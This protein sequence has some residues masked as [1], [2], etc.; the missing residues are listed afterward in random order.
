MKPEKLRSVRCL[1]LLLGL[2]VACDDDVP[3]EGDTAG[4][5]DDGVD[6]DLDG[7]IDCADDG[8]AAA[9]A[10]VA[11]DDDDSGSDDDDS[12]SDDDD[13]TPGSDPC[14]DILTFETDLS[15]TRELWVDVAAP[16]GGD[17]STTAPFSTI[18]SAVDVAGPGDAVRIRPGTYPGSNYFSDVQGTETEPIWIGGVPGE[19]RPV[20]DADGSNEGLHFTRPRYLVV[21]DL[22]V[23]SAT[24]N[25]INTDDGGAY[26]D[27]QAAHHIVFRGLEVR[28]VGPNGNHDCLKLS[29][30]RDYWVLDSSFSRCGGN[31][32]GSGVDH[33]GCHRG[34][35]ARNT[36]SELGASGIQCKGG[37][38]DVEI[39]WNRFDDAGDRSVNMGGSTGTQYFRPPVSETEANAEA[40]D[41]RVVGNLIVGAEASLAFVGCVDCVAAHNTLIDPENW[42][43]RILQESTTGA[44]YEFLPV[45][46]GRWINNLISFDRSELSTFVNIGPNTDEETFVFAGNLWYA[47]DDPAAST[48]DLPTVETGA[49][50]GLDPLLEP[51]HSIPEG[52]PAAGAGDAEGSTWLLGDI[53]GRCF[54]NPPS[55]GAWEVP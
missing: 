51:D 54:A 22:V 10:C 1:V 5:C 20:I 45:Q 35:I 55:I 28:D 33:V 29:G 38:E 3:V 49:V 2:L 44:L 7:D 40:R 13:A 16:A 8:C 6:N 46:G 18:G 34:L 53:T 52:S 26:D 39:R 32:S 21:H 43:L 15:P 36:F 50:I 14:T 19:D 17:G 25:G 9:T 41:I 30:L 12:G 37:T 4:E 11:A 23:H 31:G 42:V 48:P 27:D 47:H 24:D